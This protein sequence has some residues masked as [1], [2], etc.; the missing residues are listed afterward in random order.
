MSEPLSMEGHGGCWSN[1]HNNVLFAYIQKL[2]AQGV[3]TISIAPADIEFAQLA[4]NPSRKLPT[5]TANY[6]KHCIKYN[7]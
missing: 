5:W 6:K 4:L 1:K 7:T 3:K 2:T